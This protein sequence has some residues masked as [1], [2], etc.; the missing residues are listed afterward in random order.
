M[1]QPLIDFSSELRGDDGPA[2]QSATDALWARWCATPADERDRFAASLIAALVLE[3]R[4]RRHGVP[5]RA[6]GAGPG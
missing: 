4:C 6:G 5:V 1:N 2:R 3:R